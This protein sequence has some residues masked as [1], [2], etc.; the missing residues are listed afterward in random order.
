MENLF[1]PQTSVTKPTTGIDLVLY[2]NLESR[3]DRKESMEAQF[4]K[5][6]PDMVNVRAIPSPHGYLGCAKSH[7]KALKFANTR[8]STV[9]NVLV[10]E[11]DIQ[12]YKPEQGLDRLQKIMTDPVVSNRNWSILQLSGT[13]MRTMPGEGSMTSTNTIVARLQWSQ[14]T[15]GYVIRRSF[16]PLLISAIEKYI[17]ITEQ[18]LQQDQY[19]LFKKGYAIDQYWNSLNQTHTML[20]VFPPVFI[21]KPDYSDIEKKK[22]DYERFYWIKLG[23]QMSFNLETIKQFE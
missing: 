7:L 11:D 15:A 1:I 23:E 4:R 2:I 17:S 10:L 3:P 9:Q 21:Q 13:A 22:V 6:W 8:A 14:T 12:W 16:I 20:G 5:V 18:Q 19:P